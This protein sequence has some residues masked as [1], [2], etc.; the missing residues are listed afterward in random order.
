VIWV[1]TREICAK[2][3][4]D[5]TSI[6]DGTMSNVSGVL[7]DGQLLVKVVKVIREATHTIAG[8]I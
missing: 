4:L 2:F 3:F 1:N 6:V 8:L 7:S 5:D